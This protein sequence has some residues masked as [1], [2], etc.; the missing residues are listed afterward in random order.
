MK[1]VISAI[2]EER[3]ILFFGYESKEMTDNR[4]TGRIHLTTG[5]K[6]TRMNDQRRISKH[7]LLYAF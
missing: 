5:Q 1:S 2:L 4:D 3:Y 6:S 7:W